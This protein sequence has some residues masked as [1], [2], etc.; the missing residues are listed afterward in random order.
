MKQ[1][2][3]EVGKTLQLG[4]TGPGSAQEP[5]E[6]AAA[7]AAQPRCSHFS[8]SRKW[9][10]CIYCRGCCLERS[11]SSSEYMGAIIDQLLPPPLRYRL[12][13]HDAGTPFQFNDIQ[14]SAY[15]DMIL[16]IYTTLGIYLFQA[17]RSPSTFKPL[18]SWFTP[19]FTASSFLHT[20]VHG[21]Q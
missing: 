21:F 17:S 7:C 5:C 4:E 18:L 19:S 12:A 10:D 6:C 3:P 8:H 20:F 15:W 14:F 16:I 2:I 13:W 11:L 1:K 9:R